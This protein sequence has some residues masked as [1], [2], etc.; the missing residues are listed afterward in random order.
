[1]AGTV[2]VGSVEL[3]QARF[4]IAPLEI[5]RQLTRLPSVLKQA[6]ISEDLCGNILLVLGEIL[7]NIA[8]HAVTDPSGIVALEVSGAGG[9]VHIQTEDSGLALPAGLLGSPSLPEMGNTVED[10]P[11]GGF[12]WFIIH[13]LV[14]DMVYE[15]YDGMN[16]LSFSFEMT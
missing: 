10:L 4:E 15:R 12:G 14:D 9:R 13:S 2:A 6:G 8:E 16:R 1:M 11:E 7:N 5:S 3:F